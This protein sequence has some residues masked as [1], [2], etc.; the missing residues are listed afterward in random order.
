MNFKNKWYVALL[1]VALLSTLSFAQNPVVFQVNMNVQQFLGGFD[2]AAGD[3]VVVRGSF[4]GWSGNQDE[5]TLTDTVYA[6]T[7]DIAATGGI[8]Y[9]FVIVPGDGSADN[10]EGISNRTFDV[11]AGGATIPP[12][13]FNDQG[14]EFIDIEVLFQVDMTVQILNGNF[15]PANDWI[16]VRGSHA[17]I[18][19]WGGA[20]QL[21]Q[22]TG[23]DVYSAWITFDDLSVGQTIEYKFVILTDGN[24]DLANWEQS[25]NRSFAPD[26]S[27]PDNL[28]PPSGNGYHEIQPGVVYFS[29]ITPDDIITNDLMVNFNVDIR[30]AYGALDSIGY[31]VDVQTGDTLT[32]INEVDV[33]GFFNN[34]PWSGFDPAHMAHDDGLP[35]DDVAGDTVYAAAIQF[36]AGDPIVLI[37]KYG[38]NG[39]DVEAGFAQNHSVQ[40]DDATPEFTI[41]PPDIFG[42]QGDMYD[43]WIGVIEHPVVQTP[44]NFRLLQNHPNP[45]NPATSIGFE[46]PQSGEVTLQVFNA[47][48]EVV[49]QYSSARLN[50]GSYHIPFDGTDLASGVYF[51]QLKSGTFQ[52]SQKMVLLK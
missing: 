45:F 42:S 25:D 4:N 12:V 37:Y 22:E 13:Y 33:A 15:V 14:W 3:I 27:E 47:A 5:C 38:L 18:G 9:K 23:T 34:W 20:T 49:F 24:P 8:E 21:F 32:E 2:P 30:P 17:S 7:V 48:G 39:Y 19:N 31:I 44:D 10:W 11:P 16:V 29:N 35:P 40:L 26:G 50:A 6:A 51:Y 46:L 1:A 36:Y 28:P 41:W 52:A 43:P